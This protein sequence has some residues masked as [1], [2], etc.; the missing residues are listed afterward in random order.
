M[1]GL[2]RD[3]PGLSIGNGL[4]QLVHGL[5]SGVSGLINS[6]GGTPPPPGAINVL[7]SGG[8]SYGVG[9]GVLS[10]AGASYTVTNDVLD[11][12]GGSHTVI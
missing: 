10:S 5:W 3:T 12:A 7:S 1:S 11:S 4:Y 9:L 8:T 6:S 2:Y